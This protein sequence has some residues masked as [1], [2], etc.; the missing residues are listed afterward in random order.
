MQIETGIEVDAHSE[1]RF[2]DRKRD[3]RLQADR[4]FEIELVLIEAARTR[5]DRTV[6]EFRQR[7]VA[8]EEAVECINGVARLNRFANAVCVVAERE[9]DSRA[10]AAERVDS[11]RHDAE[12]R[13]RY[14]VLLEVLIEFEQRHLIGEE[15]R[16]AALQD[17]HP[18]REVGQILDDLKARS[19]FAAFAI[20]GLRI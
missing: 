1:A 12:E 6:F 2:D 18:V 4:H 10:D 3:A 14:E 7:P 15:R 8:D 19:H 11:H 16:I 5:H 13:R 9:I 17:L 20:R